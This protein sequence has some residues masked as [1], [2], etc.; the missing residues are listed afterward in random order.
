MNT[1]L[2]TFSTLISKTRSARDHDGSGTTNH[3]QLSPLRAHESRV[4]HH[5]RPGVSIMLSNLMLLSSTA[6]RDF[7][8]LIV[9]LAGIIRS[10]YISISGLYHFIKIVSLFIVERTCI[11][12]L[13]ALCL[14][15]ITLSLFILLIQITLSF[16]GKYGDPR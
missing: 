4:S 13:R 15:L 3:V 1:N 10:S 12:W 14:R 5:P 2:Y 8:I 9:T 11:Y 16:C 6:Q 7:V